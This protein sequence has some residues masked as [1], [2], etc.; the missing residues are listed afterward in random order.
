VPVTGF[1]VNFSAM[2][3]TAPPGFGNDSDGRS[4]VEVC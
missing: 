4:P 3:R 1:A 2:A